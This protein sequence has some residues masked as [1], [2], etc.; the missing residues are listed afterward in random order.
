M[1]VINKFI[2]YIKIYKYLKNIK[3]NYKFIK[4]YNKI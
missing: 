1:I 2:K 4:Y 3:Y